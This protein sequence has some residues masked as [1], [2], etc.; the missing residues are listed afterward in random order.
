MMTSETC[1]GSIPSR[2]TYTQ[3]GYYDPPFR[4]SGMVGGKPEQDSTLSNLVMIG[5]GLYALYFLMHKRKK[6]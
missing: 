3:K 5:I 1:Y 6:G 4:I 2:L